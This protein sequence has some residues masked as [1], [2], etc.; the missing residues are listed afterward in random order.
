MAKKAG[1]RKKGSRNRGYFYRSGRGW[2]VGIGSQMKRLLFEDGAPIK[3]KDADE[4]DL[5]EAH[6][7]W[8]LDR[9]SAVATFDE[10]PTT[11]LEVCQA[12][13]ADAKANGARKTYDDRADTLFDFCIGLPPEFRDKKDES[14]T[15]E[16]KKLTAE[17]REEMAGRRIHKGFGQLRML[18]VLP[19]H[20]T[21]WL[22]EHITWSQ[23]GRR[24]RI[25]A[26]KRAFNFA[27]EQGMIEKNPIRGF[28]TPP[29]KGRVTHITPEQEQAIYEHGNPALAIA[30]RVCIR[31]GAR[32]GTEFCT[33][34]AKHV[35]DYGER[36]EWTYAPAEIKTRKAR[37]IRISDPD[38][39]HIVR[40]QIKAHP[41]GPI[42][43]CRSGEPW[44]KKNLSLTFRRLKVKLNRLKVKIKNKD[45]VIDLDKD[46]CMYSCRHTYAKRTLQGYWTGRAT[47][48]ETL[49]KLMG[50]SPQV[51]REH[52]LVWSD[53]DN[54]HL[55]EAT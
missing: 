45:E 36:M 27:V 23:S 55:W 32:F 18:D 41:T 2:Y 33:L 3:E 53:V 11:V 51:C 44:K 22:N 49:A 43:R 26:V 13:L 4:R 42:F 12:Y 37:V 20:V 24:S 17:R 8:L 48:I 16:P 19:L 34:T 50:N 39:I 30:V 40:E 6:A 28:K 5:K 7:R 1:G 14:E 54:E 31:T 35:S 38:I 15:D 9:Q 46:C 21:K 29:S 10:N 47:N 52:Y 25:Q